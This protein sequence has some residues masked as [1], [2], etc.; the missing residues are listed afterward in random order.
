MRHLSVAL[1]LLWVPACD[2]D[3]GS[4]PPT[5]I[6][7]GSE[8]G[9]GGP[10]ETSGSSPAP[11]TTASAT[12]AS[13][14]PDDDDDDTGS[15]S[16]AFIP[17][18]DGNSIA[19]CDVWAQDCPKGE[20]CMPFANDGGIAWNATRCAPIAEDPGQP[21]DACSAEGGGLTGVDDCDLASMCWNVDPRTNTGTCVSFC[22][23]SAE[24]PSCSNTAAECSISSDGV[25]ILCLPS[26]DPLLQNCP[27]ALEACYPSVDGSSFQCYPDYSGETGSY[28]DPCAY[29]NV[30]DP[31]L[32][33][34]FA[35]IVPGCASDLCCS[36]FC[37]LTDPNPDAT[38][39]GQA[40]GQSC[41]PWFEEGT[42]PPG[43]ESVGY[44][45]IPA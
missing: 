27:G 35:S 23:G 11:T 26:C 5:Q 34:T 3:D 33:C 6:P 19:E 10:A 18:P 44:C 31:G 21:G 43:A 28:G 45:G 8:P 9:T 13:P 14:D 1:L 22:E 25:L 4:P 15:T 16:A 12:T 38:C 20:K 39:T 37:D 41:I 30:C 32:F 7:G 42:A 17:K 2:S 40:E 24:A 36:E 29:T